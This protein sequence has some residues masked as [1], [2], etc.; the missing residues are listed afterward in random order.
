[1]GPR[2]RRR[3]RPHDYR[4]PVR[5]HLLHARRH[6]QALHLPR[7]QRCVPR[8]SLV[9]LDRALLTL[10]HLQARRRRASR[11]SSPTRPSPRRAR[12]SSSG[13]G[14]APCMQGSTR[15][16]RPLHSRRTSECPK[17]MISPSRA[18]FVKNDNGDDGTDGYGASSSSFSLL[19]VYDLLTCAL[20]RQAQSCAPCATSR[21]ACSS[22]RTATTRSRSGSQCVS[23]PFSRP[24]TNMEPTRSPAGSLARQRAR[25]IVLRPLPAVR[26]RPRAGSRAARR[27]LLW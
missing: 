26:G 6:R 23:S 18:V 27:L 25:L 2:V 1:M 22:P 7:L 19:L 5:R 3:Q 12:A 15:T 11:S 10:M 16:V 20:A 8:R 13:P 14:A 4:R 24:C 17:L 9:Q 21:T